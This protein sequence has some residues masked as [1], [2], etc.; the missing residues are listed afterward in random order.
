MNRGAVI[1]HTDMLGMM[2]RYTGKIVENPPGVFQK[3]N[4]CKAEIEIIEFFL[5][6]DRRWDAP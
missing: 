6:T 3:N 1:R 4:D 2:K 5:Y